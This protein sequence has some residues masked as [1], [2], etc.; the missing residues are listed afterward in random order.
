MAVKDWRRVERQTALDGL[1]A[2]T[3]VY[4][5]R[6][7]MTELADEPGGVPEEWDGLL[8]G[9]SRRLR[10]P[11]KPRLDRQ[12]T[13]RARRRARPG[14]AARRFRA[15]CQGPTLDVGGGHDWIDGGGNDVLRGGP[16]RNFHGLRVGCAPALDGPD[17][18]TDGP[19]NDEIHSGQGN[20]RLDWQEGSTGSLAAS[21]AR[22]TTTNRTYVA[23]RTAP[24]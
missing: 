10:K 17:A 22:S 23:T 24:T 21:R 6:R 4:A 9:L 5:W 16:D 11:T 18:S 12:L 20:D 14:D 19:G 2:G 1:L 15:A 3:L 13:T 7:S 8:G